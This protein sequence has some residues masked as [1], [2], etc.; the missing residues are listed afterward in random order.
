MKRQG[1]GCHLP[2]VLQVV[3][4]EAPPF[5]TLLT[6]FSVFLSPNATYFAYFCLLCYFLERLNVH[7]GSHT[8]LQVNV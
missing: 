5:R 8:Q 6:L 2:A 4:S 1:D 3:I 7:S